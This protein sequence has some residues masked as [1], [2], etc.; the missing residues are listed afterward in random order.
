MGISICIPRKGKKI[1]EVSGNVTE[2]YKWI[3]IEVRKYVRKGISITLLRIFLFQY[4]CELFVTSYKRKFYRGYWYV[5]L[6]LIQGIVVE[7]YIESGL[8]AKRS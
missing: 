8:W 5:K 7:H 1:H 6:G 3:Y 2:R 4:Y